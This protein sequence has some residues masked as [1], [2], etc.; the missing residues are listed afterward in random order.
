MLKY[1]EQIQ[2]HITNSTEQLGALVSD[3]EY[4]RI[5]KVEHQKRIESIINRLSHA[6]DLVDLEEG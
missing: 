3:I 1:K 5:N 4:N 6:S 2:E